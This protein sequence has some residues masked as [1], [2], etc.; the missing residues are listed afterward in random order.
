[1]IMK[2]LFLSSWFPNRIDP[3]NGD[4]V[5]RHAF[6]VAGICKAAVIHVQADAGMKGHIYEIVERDHMA[7]YEIIIYF[8]RNNGFIRPLTKLSNLFRYARGYIMGYRILLGKQGKP[9][10]IHANII[11][12]AAIIAR[13]WSI[14]TGI[15]YIISEHWTLYLSKDSGNIP[16]PFVTRLAVRKAFA[17]TPVTYDLEQ[18]L[19]KH[20][21]RNNYFIIPNVVD[22]N[23]FKPAQFPFPGDKKGLLHVSSM[24]EEQKN[25]T[26]IIRTIKRLSGIRNDFIITFVGNARAHQKAL[27]RELG[28]PEGIILF[29]G[30]IT[31]AEVAEIMRQNNI[32]VMFSR[33]ENL[34]CVI[35]EALSSGLPVISSDVGG[36][37]EWIN[38][39]NGI[40]IESGNEDELLEG[41]ISMLDNYQKFDREL[42]H[43]FAVDN[44]GKEIIAG[45]FYE[46]YKNALNSGSNG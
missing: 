24:K 16:L 21:Y 25:I 45:R 27:A 28:I 15:P 1:M 23:V 41:L 5:E 4:F 29:K 20:G 22:T 38:E 30:E 12:P 18:A 34:P 6:A 10:V 31:H 7:L 42:L 43:Q 14:F 8:K 11:Y 36:I 37:H 39:S 32:L 19:R 9:D 2:V 40:L 46:I 35:L 44:F 13:L 33:I 3:F 17:I 26:G